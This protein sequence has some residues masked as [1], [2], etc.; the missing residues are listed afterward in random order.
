MMNQIFMAKQV[1]TFKKKCNKS[2]PLV[3]VFLLIL[4][5]TT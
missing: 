4:I 1:L 2:L 5:E 3:D